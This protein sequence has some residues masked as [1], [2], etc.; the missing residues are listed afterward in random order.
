MRDSF[1]GQVTGH[2]KVHHGT[3]IDAIF[4]LILQVTLAKRSNEKH[5]STFLRQYFPKG[6]TISGFSQPSPSAV[7]PTKTCGKDLGK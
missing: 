2:P 6:V 1:A 3:K 4:L 5:Q 7:P